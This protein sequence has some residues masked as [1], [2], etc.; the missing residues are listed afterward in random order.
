M[1]ESANLVLIG[2]S[3][4]GAFGFTTNQTNLLYMIVGAALAVSTG[5][6]YTIAKYKNKI[7]AGLI[8]FT[9]AIV[10]VVMM[11]QDLFV[12]NSSL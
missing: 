5:I 8:V 12:V 6:A 9:V 1:T 7:T 4:I 10:S 11:A 2:P 3:I